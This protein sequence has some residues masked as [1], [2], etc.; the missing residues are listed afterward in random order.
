MTFKEDFSSLLPLLSCIWQKQDIFHL[1]NMDAVHFMYYVCSPYD[2]SCRFFF[3]YILRRK[4]SSFAE[5]MWKTD[6]VIVIGILF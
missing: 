3:L 1:V 4:V 5:K 6:W 2:L